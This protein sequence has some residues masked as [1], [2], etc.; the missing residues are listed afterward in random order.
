MISLGLH[1]EQEI[2]QLLQVVPLRAN[3]FLQRVHVNPSVQVIQFLGHEEHLADDRLKN[4]LGGHDWQLFAVPTQ[5]THI[6]SHGR[7]YVPERKE[8]TAQVKQSLGS[9]TSQV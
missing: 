1:V 6:E 2:T 9:V 8:P 7:H 3:P 4:S 5:D